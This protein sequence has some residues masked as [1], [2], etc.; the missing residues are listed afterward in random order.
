[1]IV[2]LVLLIFYMLYRLSFKERHEEAY[3]KTSQ[4]VLLERATKVELINDWA[5][6]TRHGLRN[7]VVA[8][9]QFASGSSD[10]ICVRFRGEK[11]PVTGHLRY[12]TD[13]GFPRVSQ[14][15][16]WDQDGVRQKMNGTAMPQ[17]S[18]QTLVSSF[19]AMRQSADKL[20]YINEVAAQAQFGDA[21]FD[22]CTYEGITQDEF[23]QTFTRRKLKAFCKM[24]G[25]DFKVVSIGDNGKI[26]VRFAEEPCI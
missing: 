8:S 15:T 22:V 2:F 25:D 6:S 17:I 23:R 10:D 21:V 4:A 14:F 7:H 1:M 9:W 24:L 16:W 18:F 26:T 3:R 19:R 13:D 12:I 20:R 5:E 11:E